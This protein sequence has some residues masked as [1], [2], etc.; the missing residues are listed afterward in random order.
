MQDPQCA[1]C[2]PKYCYY[3]KKDEKILNI[4]SGEDPGRGVMDVIF[5][6]L[7]RKKKIIFFL[8]NFEKQEEQI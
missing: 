8:K 3:G 5:T 1:K 6:A 4:I 2:Q 7:I